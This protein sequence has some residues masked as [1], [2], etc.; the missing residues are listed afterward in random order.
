MSANVVS[1]LRIPIGWAVE[2]SDSS[3]HFTTRSAAQLYALAWARSH[4]PSLVRFYGSNGELEQE[5][6][7]EAGEIRAHPRSS[8]SS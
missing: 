7:I 4:M 3:R 5:Y 2:H 1:V 8:L 6:E